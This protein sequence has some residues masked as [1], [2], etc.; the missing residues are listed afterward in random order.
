ME[1]SVKKITSWNL[2]LDMART[3]NNKESISKEP[4]DEFKKKMLIAEHSPIRTIQYLIELRNVPCWA[5]QHI[6]RHDSF[7]NHNVRESNGDVHFVGTSRS[8]RTGIDRTKLYQDAPVNHTIYCNAN[9]LI[10]ISTKR[11]CKCASKETREI[12]S[13]V[14]DKIRE[15]DPILADTL[16]PSC[17]Y[18]GFCPEYDKCCGYVNT[19]EYELKLKEYRK[20]K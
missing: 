9:D 20:I 13:L 11:L 15:I 6:A 12:W 3:T 2:V 17:I 19:K 8:D 1:V 5:S 14:V 18:R 4:K 16:V 7:A 10:N